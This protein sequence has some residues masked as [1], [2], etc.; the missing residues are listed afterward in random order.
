MI[1]SMFSQPTDYL[2]ATFLGVDAVG[3][4]F[5]A[6]ILFSVVGFSLGIFWDG[7]E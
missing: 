6:A 4:S 1:E 5:S 3:W 7:E 2:A